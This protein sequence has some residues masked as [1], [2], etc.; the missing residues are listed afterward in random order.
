M[1]LFSSIMQQVNFKNKQGIPCV[2]HKNYF[3]THTCTLSVVNAVFINHMQSRVTKGVSIVDLFPDG[4]TICSS[5]F[6]Y[7]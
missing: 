4:H 6:W 2:A 5:N 3:P 1:F 7:S